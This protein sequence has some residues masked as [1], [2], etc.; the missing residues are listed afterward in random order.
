VEKRNAGRWLRRLSLA[1]ILCAILSPGTVVGQTYEQR[2]TRGADAHLDGLPPRIAARPEPAKGASHADA[3]ASNG[4]QLVGAAARAVFELKSLHARLRMRLP[5][6]ERQLVAVGDYWQLGGGNEKLVRLDLKTPVGDQV[7]TIQEIR[8]RDY[9]WVISNLPPEEPRLE[10]IGMRQARIAIGRAEQAERFS[11][12][13][14]WLLLG[15]LSRLLSSLDNS[16]QFSAPRRARLSDVPVVVLRGKWKPKELSRVG[17]VK[18]AEPWPAELPY[19][20]E[21]V[22]RE[23]AGA[24]GLFPYRIDFLKPP[25]SEEG[26]ENERNSLATIEFFEVEPGAAIH[27]SHFEFDPEEREFDDVTMPYLRRLGLV[28]A[29]TK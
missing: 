17:V 2:R 25:S 10:R 24:I 29:V 4:N 22:L 8:G 12:L 5:S 16:F 21:V 6:S 14:G 18:A 3:A 11:P 20:V 23:P 26:K 13:E 7:G 15:G 27:P 1:A 9:L 28:P 19:E